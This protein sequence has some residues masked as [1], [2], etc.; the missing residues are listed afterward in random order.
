MKA[1][2][3]WLLTIAMF[4]GSALQFSYLVDR[5]VA[6]AIN[7]WKFGADSEA[8]VQINVATPI[9][10]VVISFIGSFLSL[11]IGKL[12][13]VRGSF[14]DSLLSITLLLYLATSLLLFILVFRGYLYV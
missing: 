12:G 8:S 6:Y 10:F 14:W 9:T 11:A 3:L 2:T 13:S 4:G 7:V 5:W 1:W